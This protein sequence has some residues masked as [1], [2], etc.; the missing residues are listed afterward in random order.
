MRLLADENIASVVVLA[1]RI[2][3]HDVAWVRSCSS[4]WCL[5]SSSTRACAWRWALVPLASLAGYGAAL[6]APLIGVLMVARIAESTLDYSLSNT[7]WQALW[8]VTS[9]EAK[10]KAKQVIDTFVM[11]AGDSVSAGLVWIGARTAMSAREF[12]AVNLAL[13]FVWLGLALLLGRIHARRTGTG[14]GLAEIRT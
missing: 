9:P 6:A 14:P 4:S 1:L 12:I 8:L 3:G 2:R 10:D 7:T 5:A 11:R 13:T